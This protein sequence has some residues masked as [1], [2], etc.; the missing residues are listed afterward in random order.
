MQATHQD[1]HVRAVYIKL[2]N[3][4]YF[5]CETVFKLKSLFISK[6]AHKIGNRNLLLRRN[7]YSTNH[8]ITVI[9]LREKTTV[10]AQCKTLFTS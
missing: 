7:I 1:I 6:E 8:Q 3:M 9:I 4:N 5:S 2:Y 10:E